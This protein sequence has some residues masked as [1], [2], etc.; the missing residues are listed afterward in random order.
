MDSA[1]SVENL[2][3]DCGSLRAVDDLSFTVAA[4]EDIRVGGAE[5]CG[6]VDDSGG[7]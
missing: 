1:I 2:C 3:V 5:R 7:P 4:G 6:E